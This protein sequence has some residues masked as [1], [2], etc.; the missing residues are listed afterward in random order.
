M[1]RIYYV[2]MIVFTDE[3]MPIPEIDKKIGKIILIDKKLPDNIIDYKVM[4][5]SKEL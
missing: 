1:S 4:E 3:E 2:L 5:S